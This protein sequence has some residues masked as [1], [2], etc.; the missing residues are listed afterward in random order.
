MREH[1]GLSLPRTSPATELRPCDAITIVVAM[2]LTRGEGRVDARQAAKRG[3][4]HTSSMTPLTVALLRVAAVL[5]G[6]SIIVG[7]AQPGF[8]LGAA[9]IAA[10]FAATVLASLLQRPQK[11]G[12]R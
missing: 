12:Y 9:I 6:A 4:G 11:T 10:S 3:A 7:I 1:T 2:R 8:W 5:A